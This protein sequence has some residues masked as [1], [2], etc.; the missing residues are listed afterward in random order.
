MSALRRTRNP[1]VCTD[2]A[3]SFEWAE[4]ALADTGRLTPG[5]VALV[6]KRNPD[7]PLTRT[8][9]HYLIRLMRRDRRPGVKPKNAAAWEF[10]LF[11]AKAL[12]ETKLEETRR[13]QDS[14]AS[15]ENDE[16]RLEMAAERAYKATLQEMKVCNID[17]MTLRNLL[18][19][20]TREPEIFFDL[21]ARQ[22]ELVFRQAGTEEEDL[23]VPQF[24]NDNECSLKS[25]LGR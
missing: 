2:E 3:G 6:L 24:I 19:L 23:T 22:S 25:T 15:S 14:A 4:A 7:T 16:Q 20:R 13:E 10:I 21:E 9:R 5:Q 11:N 18:S 8:L 1:S 12:Y 17:W